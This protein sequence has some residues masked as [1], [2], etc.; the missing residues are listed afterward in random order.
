MATREHA[1]WY[2]EARD[3]K[4]YLLYSGLVLIF[5]GLRKFMTAAF[6]VFIHVKDLTSFDALGGLRKLEE[7]QKTA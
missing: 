2:A 7:N 1:A 6:R 3:P 4:T 5:F